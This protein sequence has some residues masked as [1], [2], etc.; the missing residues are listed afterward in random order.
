MKGCHHL[1]LIGSLLCFSLLQGCRAQSLGKELQ[2]PENMIV[3]PYADF[4]PPTETYRTL[5]IPKP[6]PGVES[7]KTEGGW[8]VGNIQV[9]VVNVSYLEAVWVILEEAGYF[10]AGLDYRI[11]WYFDAITLLE[12]VIEN[13]DLP[14]EVRSRT[15]RTK[16]K[17]V[18]ALGDASTVRKRMRPLYDRVQKHALE[19][20]GDERIDSVK[21][22][23]NPHE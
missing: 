5:G 14:Q 7:A 4:G 6:K 8:D 11:I 15:K 17:V 9:M 12:E 1:L 20:L 21:G 16:D 23:M 13:E 2:R 22:K 10:E 18:S 19:Q 3:I